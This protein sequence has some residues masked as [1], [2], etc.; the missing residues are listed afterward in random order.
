MKPCE[1]MQAAL[2]DESLPR[3]E[4]FEAHLASCAQC[5][6]M[7]SAHRAALRLRGET[8]SLRRARSVPEVRRRAG[9]V[10]GLMLALGGGV[11]LLALQMEDRPVVTRTTDRLEQELPVLAVEAD[12][13]DFFALAQLQASVDAD[14]RRDPREDPAAERAFGALPRW[15]APTRTQPMRSLGR[16][17][18][19]VIF[20]SEDSP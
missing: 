14:V 20:T 11:G 8:L 6:E 2:L 16:S 10:V 15:T 7:A 4:N 9:I 3:P 17:A 19:P 1:L 18:S 12:Q 5:V 13:A